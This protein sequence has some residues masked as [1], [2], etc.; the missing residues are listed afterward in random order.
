MRKGLSICIFFIFCSSCATGGGRIASKDDAVEDIDSEEIRRTD[1]N[2]AI[3]RAVDTDNMPAML[4][5]IDSGANINARA[6]YDQDRTILMAAAARGNYAATKLLI[7]KGANIRAVDRSNRNVFSYAAGG[8]NEAVIKL[9]LSKGVN[10]SNVDK[11]GATPLNY[12]T[13]SNSVA[14]VKIALSFKPEIHADGLDG[15]TALYSARTTEI[16]NLLISAGADV[17]RKNSNGTPLIVSASTRESDGLFN[18]LIDA[19]A[20]VDAQDVAGWTALMHI[21]DLPN[22]SAGGL[23]C[24]MPKLKVVRIKKLLA[25]K[26]NVNISAKN[27]E[28][29]LSNSVDRDISGG[30]DTTRV[31]LKAKANP[32]AKNREGE[33]IIMTVCDDDIAKLLRSYGAKGA[34]RDCSELMNTYT[35]SKFD[36]QFCARWAQSMPASATPRNSN[37]LDRACSNMWSSGSADHN[38]CV[39]T[40]REC[41]KHY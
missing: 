12:A 26:A 32:N 15:E 40:W 6:G 11:Y 25:A 28:T 33:T 38:Q 14:A 10:T 16:A 39:K 2:Y 34:R 9:L 20:N 24:N 23:E 22:C 5:A 18:A 3:C 13:K 31:L 30:M 19:G 37:D 29:A 4:A 7:E 36:A 35:S 1:E 27:G 41:G 8:G 17:N 21:A